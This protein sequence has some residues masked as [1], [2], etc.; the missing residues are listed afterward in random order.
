MSNITTSEV[1]DAVIDGITNLA[2]ASLSIAI[3]VK[4]GVMLTLRAFRNLAVLI[5]DAVN[6]KR[7]ASQLEREAKECEKCQRLADFIRLER[8]NLIAVRKD[9]KK[10]IIVPSKE[11]Y[12]EQNIDSWNRVISNLTLHERKIV[13]P[14]EIRVL[15][16]ELLGIDVYNSNIDEV[17]EDVKEL[18]AKLERLDAEAIATLLALQGR[19]YSPNMTEDINITADEVIGLTSELVDCFITFETRMGCKW[20]DALKEEKN[21]VLPKELEARL[22]TEGNKETEEIKTKT[23]V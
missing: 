3:G 8:L 14:S 4:N 16:Q 1:A 20:V 19:E 21:L 15:L 6:E 23:K 9:N 7:I 11:E 12:V 17:F 5:I 18:N 13:F 10:E 2:R 22:V